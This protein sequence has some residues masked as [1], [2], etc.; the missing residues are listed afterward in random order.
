LL[1]LSFDGTTPKFAQNAKTS[2]QENLSW[3]K[4][5]LYTTNMV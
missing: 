4:G 1:A 3:Q 2:S 5:S